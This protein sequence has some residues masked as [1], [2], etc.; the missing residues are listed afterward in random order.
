MIRST[1]RAGVALAA[2]AFAA[3][4][5]PHTADLVLY[6]AR[7]L[8]IDKAFS[9][10]QAVVVRGDRIVAV[11]G[12]ELAQTF[13]APKK[14]DLHGR[15]LMPGFM[16]T[17]L[18]IFTLSRRE[19]EPAKARSI[20]AIQQ[21]IRAKAAELGPGE[22]ITG[23]GWDEALLA[24]KRNLNRSDLDVA[25]PGNPVTL[26][27][28]GGHSSVGNSLALKLAGVSRDTPDPSG[29][30]IEH[31]ADGEPNGIIRER[32]DLYRNHVPPDK[33]EEVRG[34]YIRSLKHLF[35]LGIT[36]FE[37]ATTTLDD[38]PVGRGGIERPGSELTFRRF[39]GIAAETAI[40]RATLYISYPGADRLKAYPHHSGYGDIRVRLGPIGENAVDGGFTGPTAWTLVDYKGQPGFRGK[41]F[42][43]DTELQ[44]MVDTAA[45]LGWQMG[46]HAIGDAAIQQTVIAYDRAL[47][48]YP[49]MD[50]AGANRRWFLDHFTVMPPE[51]TMAL[52]A[53]DRILIAQQPNFGYNL[54]ARYNATLDGWRVTHNNSVATPVRKFGIFM[55]FGSDNLPIDPR[56]GLYYATTRRG[57]DGVQHGF[58]E[59][60]V[61]RQEA[62][63]MYTANGP[64][65][66]WEEHL[67]GT[68]E[69]GKLADMIVLDSDPLTIPE[70]RL[71]SMNVDQTYLGGKL[72]YDRSHS[73]DVVAAPH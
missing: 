68:L 46:L 10:K 44:S 66:S 34:G 14:V 59:E 16:D 47:G 53:R 64:Y 21:M 33:W 25:A 24:E 9:V 55:A 3:A 36:S 23:Y 30:V 8:T 69:P 52:M 58:A 43:S 5:T 26:V 60:A 11:G 27:R 15:V 17:H 37:S 56:V 35:S 49:G 22:W 19:I 70:E 61:S 28:A 62:L 2:P 7:V 12:N 13:D 42:F 67:K 6:D 51:A 20:E 63:R 40:P 18:H 65:L 32:S 41:G 73:G 29:G 48:R 54:E 1:L 31:G 72:V 71:L 4:A 39:Q 50:H 45:S 57:P 38:E